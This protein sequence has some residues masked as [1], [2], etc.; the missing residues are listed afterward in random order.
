M[1]SAIIVFIPA[2]FGSTRFPGK[3][4]AQLYGKAMIRIVYEKARSVLENVYVATDDQRIADEIAKDKGKVI[5]TASDHRTGTERIA[6]AV[7]GLEARPDDDTI[8]INLQGDEPF[9]PAEIILRLEEFMAKKSADIATCIHQITDPE[10]ISNPN[11]VK[12]VMNK[13][14]KALYFS[15]AIIPFSTNPSSISGKIFQHIGIYA[16]RL[17]TLLEIVKLEPGNLE[18][19][20]SLEQLRWLE[21]GYN[22]YC[23]ETDYEGF[24]ID[25]PEDLEKAQQLNLD[26]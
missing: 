21:H 10:A 23:M 6:E 8:I 18:K 26:R 16:Y 17:S 13:S 22:I 15:R 25:T 5:M 1:N 4:L 24:G 2:R 7:Q 19:A 11:R 20:E 12:V 9:F 3:P 14:E